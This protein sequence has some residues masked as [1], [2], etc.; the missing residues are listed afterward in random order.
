MTRHSRTL[1]LSVIVGAVAVAVTPIT[2]FAQTHAYSDSVT[3]LEVYATS[4]EGVFVGSASGALPGNWTADVLHTPLSGSPETAAITGGSF[5]LATTLNRSTV[6]ITGTF[7]SG[8]GSVVQTSGFSGCVD[9]RYSVNGAL[10]KVGIY[11]KPDRGSR[12]FSATLTHY[13]VL[14]LGYCLTYGASIAGTVTLNF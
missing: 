4:T 5:S 3:G 11:G 10:D 13:R 6:L 9:Q 14:I 7:V 1:L 8:G 2:A 12:N